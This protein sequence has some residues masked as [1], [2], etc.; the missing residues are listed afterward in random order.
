[1][2]E[3]STDRSASSE[4]T[5]RTYE[6]L[7]VTFDAGVIGI[8]LAR[9][10]RLNAVSL[11]MASELR[12]VVAEYAHRSDAR[13]LVVRGAGRAFCAGF[14][15]TTEP[16]D[17][18]ARGMWLQNSGF[19]AAFQALAAAPVVRVAQL[20]GHVVGAG[21]LLSAA[22]ELRYGDA[23]TTLSVPELDMG[24]PFSLGGVSTLARYIGLTRTADMVLTGRRMRAEEALS[25]GFLT[26]IVPTENLAVRVNEVARSV[27]ARP[28]ALL[29]ASLTSLNEAARDLLPADTVDLAT[30]QFA[31]DDPESAAVNAAYAEKF[32]RRR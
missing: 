16:P 20:H 2:T 9:P 29:L 21:I 7:E 6:T 24:I 11:Q 8:T 4:P 26:E 32:S 15:V 10:E 31:R 5:G 25:A 27:A 3:Q 23:T 28:A 19:H 18:S 13:V 22:C 1:M 17:T 14:D 30:M 12:A